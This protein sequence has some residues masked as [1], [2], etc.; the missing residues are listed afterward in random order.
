[1]YD[2]GG[3]VVGVELAELG[4]AVVGVTVGGASA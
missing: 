2:G 3:V 1:L 4:A